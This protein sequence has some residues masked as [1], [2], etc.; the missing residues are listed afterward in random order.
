M[1]FR[2]KVTFF[3]KYLNFCGVVSNFYFFLLVVKYL[4]ANVLRSLSKKRQAR[5]S[6]SLEKKLLSLSGISNQDYDGNTSPNNNVSYFVLP[7]LTVHE[8]E[9]AMDYLVRHHPNFDGLYN[10]YFIILFVY[11][12]QKV[13]VELSKNLDKETLDKIKDTIDICKNSMFP[14]LSFH[15][16]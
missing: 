8:L 16:K 11:F 3:F 4:M 12:S 6:R 15:F 9:K 2:K 14:Y 5:E 1:D 7:S 13:G 10:F